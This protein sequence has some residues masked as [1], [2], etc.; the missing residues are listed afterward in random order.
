MI[1]RTGTLC[2]IIFSKILLS[3]CYVGSVTQ[4]TITLESTKV[5]AESTST[6][7][8]CDTPGEPDIP[9]PRQEAVDGFREVMEAELVGDLVLKGGC[10]RIESIYNEDSYLPVWPPEFTLGEASGVITILDGEGQ[11]VARVGEEIYMGGGIGAANAIADCARRQLPDT[12]GGPFW[13]V[14]EGVRPNLQFDSAL[15]IPEIIRMTSR[16]AIL[17]HK[18]PLLDSWVKEPSTITGELHLYPPQRCPRIISDSG[19]TDA[20]PIWPANYSLH[21]N[22]DQVEILDGA[23]Q[24]IAREG[25]QVTLYGGYIPISWDSE[26]YR[27]LYYDVPGDCFGPYWIVISDGKSS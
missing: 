20:L 21:I 9:F 16:T 23:G 5:I 2:V 18:Y 25:E 24:V 13:I 8:L 7:E 12:C 10:L 15:I 22:E 11:V 17:I 26:E 19:M 3:A 1:N 4:S 6:I 27:R 14:G